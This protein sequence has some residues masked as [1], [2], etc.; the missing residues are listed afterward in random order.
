[1]EINLPGIKTYD[2]ETQHRTG[3][4]TERKINEVH[5]S[6]LLTNLRPYV[7]F[8]IYILHGIKYLSQCH[9]SPECYRNYA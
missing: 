2:K 6:N 9:I 3:K 4:L 1:M 7:K 8:I 5:T